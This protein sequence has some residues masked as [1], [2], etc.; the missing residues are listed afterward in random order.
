MTTYAIG[1]IQG[2][3]D[4]LRALLDQ[5]RFEP[6]RDRLWLAGDLVN[7]GPDSLK[8]LRFVRSLGDSVHAVL[9]NHDLHLLAC[10][11]GTETPG[12]KDTFQAVLDAP[13]RDELLHWLAACPLMLQD[14]TLGWSMLHAGL[15]P[16]WTLPQALRLARE[17]QQ[18]L[19]A[20]DAADFFRH[21]YGNEP[22][23]W[24]EGLSGHARTRFV[25]NCFTRLRYCRSDGSLALRLKSAP[26][27]GR[28]DVHP[29]F[30]ADG[31]Q[32]RDHRIV[33][34][35]WSTLGRV[36]WPEHRV[37]GLDSGCVWGG[38]LT[39]MALETGEITQL[40]CAGHRKPAG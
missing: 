25:V 30:A 32:S 19:Q 31:R 23:V 38:A 24:S 8:T 13:D 21:M 10:A 18:T 40:T 7:R 20:P 36:A 33:F 9:G 17:A 12:S 28:S 27:S 2:C 22:T 1:D 34:G 4:E 6:G 29:W 15:A 16:Q 35:H 26:D 39:A 11:S 14:E 3:H 5:L 37:W